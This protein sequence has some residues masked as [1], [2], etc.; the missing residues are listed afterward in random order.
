MIT[1]VFR[2]LHYFT[3][4]STTLNQYESESSYKAN[5]ANAIETFR[6]NP[7]YFAFE[8]KTKS[9]SNSFELVTSRRVLHLAAA[10][11]AVVEEWIRTLRRVIGESQFTQDPLLDVVRERW[12]C[13]VDGILSGPDFYEV[14]Y[15]TKQPLGLTFLK[16]CGWAVVKKAESANFTIGSVLYTVN[17]EAVTLKTFVETM[18]IL[19]DWQPPL[20][21]GFRHPPKKRGW[22]SKQSRGK[23]SIVKNWKTRYF[24][25]ESGVL[26]YYDGDAK[27]SKMKGNIGLIGSAVM[28][29]THSETGKYFT[30]KIVEGI[31]SI[32]MQAET[33][34]EM[35]DWAS[36][37]YH[38]SSMA[39]GG[40]YLLEVERE[41][42]E[43]LKKSK[44]QEVAVHELGAPQQASS[45]GMW[46]ADTKEATNGSGAAAEEASSAAEE[47]GET[48]NLLLASL[49][50]RADMEEPDTPQWAKSRFR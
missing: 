23:I 36:V 4:T 35:M 41:R 16:I 6:L 2:D 8:T 19:A 39:S 40:G 29:L 45:P 22:L 17:D 43:K 34:D 26:S 31:S 1:S 3:L 25:L 24:V 7:Q 48:P 47:P 50:A 38:A 42:Q 37:L 10:N 32:V 28:L 30:F 18:K 49:E 21:L 5:N 9:M 13:N 15:A 14:R 44:K 46:A 11:K 27:T 20:V 12:A 33:V